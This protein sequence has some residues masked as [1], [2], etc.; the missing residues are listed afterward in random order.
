MPTGAMTLPRRIQLVK[1]LRANGLRDVERM[2]EDEL[3][4]ALGRLRLVLP[5]EP[6]TKSNPSSGAFLARPADPPPFL[7][8]S[9]DPHALPRFREPRLSLPDQQRTFLRAIAV[10]PRLLFCT[11]DVAQHERD[12]LEG[13]VVLTLHWRDYLGDPPTA[14]E[15]LQQQPSARV[16]VDVSSPGWYLNVPGERLA[17][18]AALSVV[19]GR[20]VVAS[21]VTLTPPARPAP[22]GPLWMATL[23]PSL[24]RRKLLQRALMKGEVAELKRIGETDARSLELEMIDEEL[25]SSMASVRLPWLQAPS[26]SSFASFPNRGRDDEGKS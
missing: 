20:R 6:S 16:D 17:V 15:L 8:D 23:P 10:K 7:D 4:Q 3:K 18:V 14:Q 25:P 26:S 24:D 11:W 2:R 1:L 13:P 9:D 12:Q 22:P 19:Q 5:S 21:N